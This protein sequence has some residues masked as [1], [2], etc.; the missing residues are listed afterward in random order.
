MLVAVIMGW[1]R[2]GPGRFA[3]RSRILRCDARGIVCGCVPGS[4][5]GCVFGIFLGIVS[6]HSK[7]SV[8]WNS[9]DVLPTSIIP[10]SPGVFELFPKS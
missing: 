9:E 2:S 3:M 1:S 7:P 6:S 8:A 4:S 10:K 5:C